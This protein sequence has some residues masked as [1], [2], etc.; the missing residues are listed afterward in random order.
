MGPFFGGS[1]PA[2]APEVDL[3]FGEKADSP[4]DF[5]QRKITLVQ[6]TGA[7]DMRKRLGNPLRVEA[8]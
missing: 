4:F 3:V 7:S 1:T 8:M 2:V 6:L 5:I